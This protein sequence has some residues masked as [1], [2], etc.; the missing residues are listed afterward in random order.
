MATTHPLQWTEDQHATHC[1]N[2]QSP[3]LI[4]KGG[5]ERE[6]EAYIDLHTLYDDDDAGRIH[7]NS[8]STEEEEEED[9]MNDRVSLYKRSTERIEWQQMLH[10][11]LVGQVIQSEKKRFT[12]IRK[13]LTKPTAEIWISIRALLQ[14][15]TLQDEHRFLNQSRRE[16]NDVVKMIYHFCVDEQQEE[17]P[18]DQ[19][20]GALR[21]VDRVENLFATR[22]DLV[23]EYP[24]YATTTFQ[25][26]L[27]AL[28]AWY[29]TTHSLRMQKCILENWMGSLVPKDTFVERLLKESALQDTFNKR[30][31]SALHSLL[32]KSKETIVT[33]HAL[34]MEMNLPSFMSRLR[35]LAT[36]PTLLIQEA[37]K[38]RLTY[39]ELTHDENGPKTV[40]DTMVEDYRS[41]L[42][43]ACRV[44]LQYE[45]LASPA[46]GWDLMGETKFMDTVVLH[47]SVRLYF[48]MIAWRL[49]S[50]KGNTIRQCDIMEREWDYIRYTVCKSIDQVHG[51]C[52]AQICALVAN[53]LLADLMEDY[54]IHLPKPQQQH[55]YPPETFHALWTRTRKLL[56]F[57]KFFLSQFENATEYAID[58]ENS[59]AFIQSLQQSGHSLLIPGTSGNERVYLAASPALA[60][61]E[62][63]IAAIIQS[64]FLSDHVSS[65]TSTPNTTTPEDYI[66]AFSQWQDIVWRG[67]VQK[68][69]VPYVTME[70]GA[71]RA[72]IISNHRLNSAKSAFLHSLSCCVTTPTSNNMLSVIHEH[73]ANLACIN[74]ELVG[75]KT[76]VWRLAHANIETMNAIHVPGA[77]PDFVQESFSAASDLCMRASRFLDKK[78]RHQ[79]D[80]KLLQMAIRWISFITDECTPTD[81]RTF[82]WAV[83]ALDFT[84]LITRGNNVLMLQEHDFMHLQHYVARCITLLISHFDVLGTRWREYDWMTEQHT[85]RMIQ[86]QRRRGKRHSHSDKRHHEDE[87]DDAAVAV[88]SAAAANMRFI[89][90]EWMRHIRILEETRNA[91]ERENKLVG[92]VLENQKPEDRSML[93]LAPSASSISF[94]WQQGRFIGAGTF[95]SVYLAINLDTSCMMAV[96]ELR[97]PDSDTLSS[98]HKTIKEEMKVM[99][100]LNHPNIVQ[101]YGIEVHRDKVY[102]FME[103]CENGSLESLLQHGGY[104]QD[105]RYIIGYTHQLLRG[106]VYLHENNVVHRDIKPDNILIDYQGVVKLS[107]FGTARILVAQGQQKTA[108]RTTSSSS[109]SMDNNTLAG[110]PV[111]M[112]P[113][114]ITGGSKGRMGSMD[115]WSL[116]CCIVQMVTGRRPWS[117][118]ENEWSVMYHVVTGQPPLPECSQLSA[119]GMNFL[120]KCFTRNPNK[121]PTAKE[122][123]NHPW[124]TSFD[125]M[126]DSY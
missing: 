13:E 72:R 63:A 17:Q 20:A 111:Y 18:Y 62:E 8:S 87:D 121:R 90:N 47:D 115:I 55:D 34:F 85:R 16:M 51:Q 106:L 40:I 112:A 75:V 124:I 56:Q 96:K 99:D 94:K 24:D 31:L 54:S 104:I 12:V 66:I 74:K 26:R 100:M 1:V 64:S 86:R 108:N 32:V 44:K 67:R 110:T 98:F 49:K 68:A 59:N 27:D 119:L 81:R 114:I 45:E 91:H 117:T 48:K 93:Y 80:T 116:G 30:T 123:L 39:K 42:T 4:L 71:N 84:Q 37:L 89:R 9:D 125:N 122:L 82:R 3:S 97:F 77:D 11:V 101:C 46:P 21:T 65:S 23:Q 19:V 57:S 50:E 52:S 10:S 2:V 76:I 70:L 7:D 120:E 126:N 38:L 14:G 25:E 102:I 88:V 107:D 92:R 109:I 78:A 33:N 60:G 35:E 105:E 95:G 28:N 5:Q 36:F 22:A 6:R 41:L 113:E 15:H 79:L 53:T 118:L 73:K 103:Y 61:R 43:L 58:L 29:T 83:T 69:P